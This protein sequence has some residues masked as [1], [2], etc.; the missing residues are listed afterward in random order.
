MCEL[1]KDSPFFIHLA[2]TGEAPATDVSKLG[3]SNKNFPLPEGARLVVFT[4]QDEA[5]KSQLGKD[6]PQR[7]KYVY[8]NQHKEQAVAFRCCPVC[9]QA[10]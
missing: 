5:D 8:R 9:K 10:E 3:S 4:S 7:I 1:P 6:R 2:R